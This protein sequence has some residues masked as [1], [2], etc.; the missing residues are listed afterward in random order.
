ML[1]SIKEVATC[2]GVPATKLRYYDDHGLLP[3]VSR[4]A[5]GY[6]QF[7][8]E[9]VKWVS[10]I[11]DLRRTGLPLNEIKQYI[12]YRFH[13]DQTTIQRQQL[14]ANQKAQLES[15]IKNL[16]GQLDF[17][18]ELVDSCPHLYPDKQSEQAIKIQA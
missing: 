4:N 3:F 9:S 12:T 15:E 14:F 10:I 18:K 2:T 5:N 1:Y 13:A 8:D 6:R 11:A 7:S 16:Q 17:L